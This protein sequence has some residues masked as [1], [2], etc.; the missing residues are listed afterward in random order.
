MKQ[1]KPSRVPT[2]VKTDNLKT[3]EAVRTVHGSS[4]AEEEAEKRLQD[5]RDFVAKTS[6]RGYV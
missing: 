1:A 2:R 3:E 6:R 4:R 5:E